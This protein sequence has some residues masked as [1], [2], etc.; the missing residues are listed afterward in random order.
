MEL[1]KNKIS[2]KIFVVLD[3]PGGSEF[4]VVTPEGK[5]KWI[6]RRLFAVLDVVEP[7]NPQL[8]YVLTKTQEDIY[9]EYFNE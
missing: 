6:E 1:V 4:M 2:G 5:V 8:N 3:D 9:A 7:N